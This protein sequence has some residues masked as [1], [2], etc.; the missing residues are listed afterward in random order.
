MGDFNPGIPSRGAGRDNYSSVGPASG[1][2]AL[3]FLVFVLYVAIRVWLSLRSDKKN[4]LLKEKKPV[5]KRKIRKPAKS[6]DML[7]DA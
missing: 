6:D 4:E 2:V 1:I 5:K 7:E 3:L